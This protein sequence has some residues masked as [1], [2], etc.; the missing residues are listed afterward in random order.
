MF[1]VLKTEQKPT[2]EDSSDLSTFKSNSNLNSD[3]YKKVFIVSSLDKKFLNKK[4]FKINRKQSKI[5]NLSNQKS[6]YGYWDKNEHNKFIEALYIY[7]CDWDKIRNYM[8]DR[9]YNQIVSHSQKFFLRLKK[10]KDT[11]LGLDFTSTYVNNLNII[12]DIVKEK[13][14]SLN[15]NKRLL[16][17]ISEKI[18]FGKNIQRKKEE[19]LLSDATENS[20]NNFDLFN[21]LC[22]PNYFTSNFNPHNSKDYINVV[23]E[24][25]DEVNIS[26]EFVLSP[27]NGDNEQEVDEISIVNIDNRKNIIFLQ[28]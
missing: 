4:R 5:K 1:K 18:S 21:P 25:K 22:N 20:L 16:Q 6:I 2:L 9:T 12:V 24:N 14:A 17:I 19:Q 3:T 8:G 7:N 11:G 23:E 27:I 15:I 26:S 10:F 28:L 13:E